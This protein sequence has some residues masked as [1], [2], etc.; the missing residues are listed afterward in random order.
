MLW[1]SQELLQQNG[2]SDADNGDNQSRLS[3]DGANYPLENFL[4]AI[5]YLVLKPQFN[6]AQLSFCRQLFHFACIIRSKGV[7][8]GLRLGAGL[9][10]RNIGGFQLI[11]E[12]E[13]IEY[14]FHNF[15]IMRKLIKV[16]TERQDKQGNRM[17]L[18]F[19]SGP[20]HFIQEAVIPRGK[21]AFDA[22]TAFSFDLF[23]HV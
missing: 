19:W 4:L 15:Q 7:A 1:E 22:H 12:F 17:K 23:E 6:F 13:G 20:D 2:N 14:A 10:V 11:V 5:L 8:H 18:C 16:N 3:N 21:L 9:L